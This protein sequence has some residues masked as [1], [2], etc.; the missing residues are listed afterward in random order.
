MNISFS[1]QLDKEVFTSRSTTSPQKTQQKESVSFWQD[2][3]AFLSGM[4]SFSL[5]SYLLHLVV[6]FRNCLERLMSIILAD[7]KIT[8]EDLGR[9]PF[10]LFASET[11]VYLFHYAHLSFQVI[12]T[13]NIIIPELEKGNYQII[14]RFMDIFNDSLPTSASSEAKDSSPPTCSSS[15]CTFS[16]PFDPFETEEDKEEEEPK[17]PSGEEQPNFEGLFDGMDDRKGKM[18]QA[19]TNLICEIVSAFPSVF[20]LNISLKCPDE[21]D[22]NFGPETFLE[23]LRKSFGSPGEK[24]EEKSEENSERSFD[25]M[26]NKILEEGLL[27][28]G[29]PSVETEEKPPENTSA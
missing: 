6:P 24:N 29:A 28:F 8:V 9:D 14:F 12:Q 15:S 3:L 16:P 1:F 27:K 5:M 18:L 7:L 19:T 23:K 26:M 21:E 20:P 2:I 13:L 22:R 4:N 10:T 11:D 25:E 17:D